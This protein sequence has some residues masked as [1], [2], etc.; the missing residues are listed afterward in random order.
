MKTRFRHAY[1]YE[2]KLP[3]GDSTHAE[4]SQY[5]THTVGRLNQTYKNI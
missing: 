4:F 5:Q 2:K 3:E 1:I